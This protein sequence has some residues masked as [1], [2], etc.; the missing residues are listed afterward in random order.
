MLIVKEEVTSTLE[1][2]ARDAFEADHVGMRLERGS[3]S[4]SRSAVAAAVAVAALVALAGSS[5]AAP[6][7]DRRAEALLVSAPRLFDGRRLI[8]DGAVLIRG[9]KVVRVGRLAAL[10]GVAAR[11]VALAD[12]TILPGFIDLHVHVETPRL[13]RAGLMT[14]RNLGQPLGSLSPPRDRPGEQRRRGAGPIVSVPGGYPGN[15]WGS[16]IHIDVRGPGDAERVVASLVGRGASVIKV[17]L[18]PGPGDW[19]VLT[20]AELTAVVAAAHERGREVTAHVER[21]EQLRRALDAGVDQLAHTPCDRTDPDAMRDAARA[22]IRIVATLHVQGRCPAKLA[23]ARA[24][25]AAGGRLLYGSDHGVPGIP[26]GI[27]TTELR[28]LEQAG[29]TRLQVLA[30]ATAEA[31]EA[32]GEAPLG[33]LV[34]GAPADLFAVRGNPFRNLGALRRPLLAIAGGKRVR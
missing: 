23:N 6:V 9:G 26:A 31:G 5:R 22:G 19:P 21:I 8:A 10:R 7:G 15:V 32:L 29:L 30:A 27:D 20:L 3:T 4:L 33:S 25:V 2:D 16:A 12:A 18:E 24:F 14:V 13:V 28:L 11:Q 34:A 17:A 1:P